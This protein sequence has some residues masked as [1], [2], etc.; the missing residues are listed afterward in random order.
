MKTFIQEVLDGTI[1]PEEGSHCYADVFTDWLVAH[2]RDWDKTGL[3]YDDRI[4]VLTLSTN[5]NEVIE[6]WLNPPYVIGEVE[7]QTAPLRIKQTQDSKARATKMLNEALDQ[8]VRK[9]PMTHS[10]A[11]SNLHASYGG[12]T[13]VG[14]LWSD[15][16]ITP[17]RIKKR[18]EP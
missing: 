10:R 11:H 3:T 7:M 17:K 13:V 5:I 8:L 1:Q 15:G 12:I 4:A 9:T 18:G 14:D 2:G 16:R 6:R